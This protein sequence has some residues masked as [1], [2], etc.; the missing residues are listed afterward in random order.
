MCVIMEYGGASKGTM[1]ILE[2]Q[3]TQGWRQGIIEIE[4]E[5]KYKGSLH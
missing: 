5:F 3:I 2:M 1:Q 4:S